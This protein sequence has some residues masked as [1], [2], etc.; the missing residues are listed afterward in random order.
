MINSNENRNM[1]LV[2]VITPSF[3][4][5]KYIRETIES[6]LN[7]NYPRIEYW[8]IDGGSTDETIDILKS[9]GDRLHWISE[10]DG[11]QADA[12]NK[13]IQRAKGSIIGWLNSDDTYLEDAITHIVQF[14]NEH[15]EADMVYGEGYFIDTESRIVDR[16]NT[17]AFSRSRLAE[18]CMICQPTAFFTKDIVCK[19]GLLDKK[20]DLCMDYELWMKISHTGN[21]MYMPRYLAASRM[22]TENK[23]L[24]RRTE[25]HR[26]V[27]DTIYQYYGYVPLIWVYGYVQQ[28]NLGKNHFRLFWLLIRYHMKFNHKHLL[29]TLCEAGRLLRNKFR[30]R[31]GFH[32][33]YED[34]WV[35]DYYKKIDHANHPFQRVV[36][37]GAHIWP[38][39]DPITV[40][41]TLDGRCIG[42]ILL[43]KKGEFEKSILLENRM[44]AG[45][46]KVE[47][48]MS[49]A[50]CPDHYHVIRDRRRL[51]F[52][53]DRITLEA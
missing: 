34:G 11:G 25:V 20:L 8:V 42:S 28:L 24:S 32:G 18:K 21:I 45:R 22:Y 15:P 49:Q 41:V 46:H 14:M 31:C 10:P 19:A 38:L 53:L 33:R 23:T 35:S 50:Y 47:L 48:I 44:A 37:T 9:F 43:E 5:G 4:Q 39:M 30:I 36:I 16:Y 3:N 12:V 13:G 40:Q 17:E 51:S 7:Q 1:P 26:E 52:R 29:I 2:T 27:C 6:V